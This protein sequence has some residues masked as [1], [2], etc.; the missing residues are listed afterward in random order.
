MS[1]NKSVNRMEWECSVGSQTIR[2]VLMRPETGCKGPLLICSHGYGGTH[3]SVVPYAEAAAQQGIAAYAF[4][5][6]GGGTQSASDGATTDMSVM[7]EVGDL[8]AVLAQAA[9]W[10]FVDPSRIV[11]LGA[12]QGGYVSAVAAARRSAAVAALILLYPAFVAGDDMH[13][14]FAS[15]DA[16]PEKLVYRNGLEVGRR[17]FADLWDYDP[18]AEIGGYGGPVLIIHGTEDSVVP[19]SYS[20]RARSVYPRAELRL[21][22]GGE[23]GFRG[24]QL[25]D[26]EADVLTFLRQLG[27]LAETVPA[28][29]S[30]KLATWDCLDRKT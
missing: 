13:R 9:D 27:F 14:K 23:H 28:T 3:A 12:S 16:I 11:L 30:D 29:H 17:Y 6:R 10:P 18:Y 22:R 1:E 2:G 15:L 4:D 25:T 26:S 7:T 21:I 19:L 5:F 8:E 24:P 20:E